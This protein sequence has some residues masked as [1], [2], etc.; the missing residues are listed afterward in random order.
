MIMGLAFHPVCISFSDYEES[1]L[2][3][4][5]V[6]FHEHAIWIVYCNL[7]TYLRQFGYVFL[8]VKRQILR[9]IIFGTSQY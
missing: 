2:M 1:R 7:L 6:A 9:M 5:R 4:I 3:E 8:K